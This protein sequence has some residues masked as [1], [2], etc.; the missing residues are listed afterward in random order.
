MVIHQLVLHTYIN[1]ILITLFL[2]HLYFCI[3][4]V[5]LDF[6]EDIIIPSNKLQQPSRFDQTEKI[7]VWIYKT[8]D[9]EKHDLFMDAGN[10]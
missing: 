1:Q 10:V 3:I 8:E 9:G 7:W 5:T 4:V 6:F 2:I